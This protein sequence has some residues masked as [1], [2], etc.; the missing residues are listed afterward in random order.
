MSPQDIRTFA[1]WLLVVL[2]V[3]C[4]S[5]IPMAPATV[6]RHATV[7]FSLLYV[8]S[9]ELRKRKTCLSPLSLSLDTMVANYQSADRNFHCFCQMIFTE[10]CLVPRVLSL[11]F[12][13][14]SHTRVKPTACS[15]AYFGVAHGNLRPKWFFFACPR[16]MQVCVHAEQSF[17]AIFRTKKTQNKTPSCWQT[18][19]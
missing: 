4:K 9:C 3:T 17:L 18:N 1:V 19:C 13:F 2:L 15:V 8:Y 10:F 5:R 11:V 7:S 16:V 14:H 6:V 12:F